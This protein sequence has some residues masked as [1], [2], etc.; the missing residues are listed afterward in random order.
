MIYIERRF[1]TGCRLCKKECPQ[2]AI[3]II[4]YKAYVDYSKCNGCNRCIYV[5]PSAAIKKKEKSTKKDMKKE[6][7]D[8]GEK[9]EKMKVNIDKLERKS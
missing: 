2:G 3:K 7:A 5:C 4:N 9:I 6:L 8:I 1:C